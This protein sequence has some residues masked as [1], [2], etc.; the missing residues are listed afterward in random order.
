MAFVQIE[1]WNASGAVDP[2]IEARPTPSPKIRS[3]GDIGISRRIIAAGAAVAVHLL[4]L[5]MLL[6]LTKGLVPPPSQGDGKAM[7]V[8]TLTGL[9]E[10][11]APEPMPESPAAASKETQP[12]RDPLAALWSNLSIRIPPPASRAP[13]PTPGSGQSA[14]SATSGGGSFDPYA[15]AS[16]A[17][18]NWADFAAKS[19]AKPNSTVILPS[20]TV[21]KLATALRI[22]VSVA[23][24]GIT[25]LVRCSQPGSIAEIKA[26]E[27][28][29]LTQQQLK[30]AR[31]VLVG[32]S[33]PPA[34]CY[35]EIGWIPLHPQLPSPFSS[36]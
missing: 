31:Q 12:E 28:S 34:S 17:G 16:L 18:F 15:G 14:A 2:A 8:F 5:V 33:I 3:L 24:R 26:D 6:S 9:Q 35:P 19:A 32:T 25:L 20:S 7:A 4:L 21:A 36:G 22:D 10:G 27:S 11:N 13:S 23:R 29:S 1:T 30:R